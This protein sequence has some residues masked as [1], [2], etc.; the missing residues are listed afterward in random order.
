MRT[1]Y[2][3]KEHKE[4]TEFYKDKSKSG[5]HDYK[6]KECCKKSGKI[7]WDK[8][9]ENEENK[10]LHNTKGKLYQENNKERIS[11]Y[12]KNWWENSGRDKRDERVF[13]MAPGHRKQMLIEQDYRCA[14]CKSHQ[15]NFT[16]ALSID[17]N[18]TNGQV[19]GLLCVNCNNMLG[20]AKDNVE[21]LQAGIDYLNKTKSLE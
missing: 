15:D 6:C 14:I 11:S 17:H 19:R 13:C 20:D 2:D 8:W 5:G 7:R 21:R 9:Y 10:K 3:C 16:N 18:H 12:Q 4:L 1:C